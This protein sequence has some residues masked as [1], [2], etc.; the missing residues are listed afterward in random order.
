MVVPEVNE[1]PRVLNKSDVMFL[2]ADGIDFV[3]FEDTL[4]FTLY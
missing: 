1:L 4:T 2:P 3:V